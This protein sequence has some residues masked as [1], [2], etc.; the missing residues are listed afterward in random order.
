MLGLALAINKLKEKVGSAFY[1]F[2]IMGTDNTSSVPFP[3]YPLVL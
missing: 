2:K 1:F 3:V